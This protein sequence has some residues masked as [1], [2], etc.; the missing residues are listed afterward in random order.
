MTSPL[1]RTAASA[2]ILAILLTGSAPSA[3]ANASPVIGAKQATPAAQKRPWLYENSDVPIDPEWLFGE[4]PNGVRYAIRRNGVPPGQV[5]IR[6]RIDT[7]ALMEKP[8]ELGFAHYM[9][10]D[11]LPCSLEVKAEE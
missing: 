5:S 11:Y 10:H 4:L 6:L 2:S 9:E 1:R 7:G 3:W 8:T